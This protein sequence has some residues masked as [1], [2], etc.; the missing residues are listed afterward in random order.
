MEIPIILND[1]RTEWHLTSYLSMVS[2]PAI[3]KIT[4]YSEHDIFL[5]KENY[6]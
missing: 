5:V 6:V 4:Q 3:V 2:N 1:N